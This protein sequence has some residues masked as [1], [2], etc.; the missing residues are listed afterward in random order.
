MNK[1]LKR[2]NDEIER[3]GTK[4]YSK[5]YIF[6]IQGDLNC[7]LEQILVSENKMH[8]NIT[9]AICGSIEIFLK[10]NEGCYKSKKLKVHQVKDISIIVP[11]NSKLRCELSD[12]NIVPLKHPCKKTPIKMFICCNIFIINNDNCISKCSVL[13]TNFEMTLTN[14]QLE[15]VP[16]MNMETQEFMIVSNTLKPE[17]YEIDSHEEPQNEEIKR[18][19]NCKTICYCDPLGEI[20]P[21]SDQEPTRDCEPTRDHEP[22]RDCEPTGDH[23]PTRDCEPTNDQEPTRDCEPTRN[24]EPT[25]DCEPTSDQEPTRDC[26]PTSDQEPTRDC[27]PTGDQEPTRDCESTRD[28]EPTGDCEPTGDQEPTRDCEPTRDHEPTRDC[29]PTRD[30]EPTRDCE[31]TNDHELTR[32][33]EPTSDQEPT[34][35]CEP[36]GDQEPTRDCEPTRDREPTGDCEPTRDQEPTR[37]YEPIRDSNPTYEIDTVDEVD[38]GAFNNHEDLQHIKL[39]H[40]VSK[41]YPQIMRHLASADAV[42][43]STGDIGQLVDDFGSVHFDKVWIKEESRNDYYYDYA[44]KLTLNEPGDYRIIYYVLSD[45]VSH[46]SINTNERNNSPANYYK[47][48]DDNYYIDS[49]ETFISVEKVPVILQ[50]QNVTGNAIIISP[51]D[52]C[53]AFIAIK[54]IY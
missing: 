19:C 32:D 12:F 45:E 47:G 30:H 26:E 28:R 36:T 25:R 14:V 4:N 3:A 37:D 17:Q 49:A 9:I 1:V 13:V 51:T 50:L 16:Y 43:V 33:C 31:P 53:I 38:E 40:L 18:K 22:T 46:F 44:G 8:P 39:N 35:D 34:R 23:E 27:E 7:R 48:A 10:N 15:K 11:P 52:E 41:N 5:D 21:T 54:K 24:Q 42:L 20:E 2:T 6:D 29:E